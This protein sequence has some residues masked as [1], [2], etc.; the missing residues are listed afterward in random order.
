M[1]YSTD[2]NRL[3]NFVIVSRASLH[4]HKI[5]HVHIAHYN[6]CMYTWI[7]VMFQRLAWY[8]YGMPQ[9]FRKNGKTY[10]DT[11]SMSLSYDE[12]AFHVTTV[13]LSCK[14]MESGFPDRYVGRSM[15]DCKPYCEQSSHRYR[16]PYVLQT[17]T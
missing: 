13:K 9:K 2:R 10:V 5:E 15:S 17:C 6:T 8:T 12:T 11:D 7:S 14:L 3:R 1:L 16:L 4:V